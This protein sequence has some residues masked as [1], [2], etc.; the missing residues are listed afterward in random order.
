MVEDL[1]MADDTDLDDESN[2]ELWGDL[3]GETGEF[4][5]LVESQDETTTKLA[6]TGGPPQ[7]VDS[8]DEITTKLAE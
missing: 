4:P 8:Q 2:R 1:E 7:L 3:F 5:E 6:E